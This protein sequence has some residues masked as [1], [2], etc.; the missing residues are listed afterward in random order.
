MPLSGQ[1]RAAGYN[2]RL[3]IWQMEFSLTQ[4]VDRPKAGRQFFEEV[5]RDN[6]DLGR[7]DR[8][9]LPVCW[10]RIW[11]GLIANHPTDWL[12]SVPA[13]VLLLRS[14]NSGG[15]ERTYEYGCH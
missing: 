8:V 3:S 1:D 7:P 9:Q 14:Y 2:F 13:R 10:K 5:I 15:G 6:L 11:T 12:S 4:I